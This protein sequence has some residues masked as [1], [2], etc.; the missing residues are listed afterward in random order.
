MKLLI[1][2]SVLSA[3]FLRLE[4]D[5]K[6]I[7]DS[8]A[9]LF[10]LDIMDGHFVPNI[11]FGFGIV[12]QIK[13]IAKKP[14][15]VHLM[16]EKPDRYIDEFKKS[17]ADYLSVHYETCPHLHRTIYTIKES[18]MKAGVVINP[19]N[20]VELLSDIV[21]DADYFLLMSVNPGFGGQSFI[22]QTINRIEKLSN[23][24]S[25]NNSKALIEVDGGVGLNNAKQLADAGANILVAGNSIF[26]A[27]NPIETIALLK[28]VK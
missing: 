9:D 13:K 20:P 2:P 28:D 7:N 26:S 8:K 11:T 1:A 14:L 18:G 21:N 27:E 3:N 5:I 19:H 6:L 10:H 12:K 25:A 23:I 17:G 24:I 22:K 15:D 4:D 16:I